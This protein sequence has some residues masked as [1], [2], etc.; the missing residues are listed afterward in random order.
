MIQKEYNDDKKH[1]HVLSYGAG[2]QSTALLLMAL[3]GEINNV[4]PDYIIFSN[5]GWEPQK[6]YDWLTK[7]GTYIKKE[8]NKEIIITSGGN[9]RDEIMKNSKNG[10]ISMPVYTKDGGMGFRQCTREYKITPINKKIRELLGYQPYKRV[11]E[12]VHI[13]KGISIDEYQRAKPMRD[14]WQTAE[15]PLIEVLEMD[16]QDCI[17][18]VEREGL[19]TPP[20]SSCSGCPFNNKARWLEIRNDPTS[21]ADVVMM[22]RKLREVNPNTFLHNSKQPLEDVIFD[23]KIENEIDLFNNECEGM[24]G[25]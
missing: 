19:G 14:K 23:E 18:Y 12:M 10:F 17:E 20:R 24:C 21:W 25:L 11:K 16:R 13:W 4:I 7:I 3:K 8:F 22:D 6:V 15:H 2:T 1:I 5:T 9:I